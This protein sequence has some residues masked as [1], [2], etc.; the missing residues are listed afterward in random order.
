MALINTGYEATGTWAPVYTVPQG[1]TA[2]LT[3]L[4]AAG[5]VAETETAASL[6]VRWTDSSTSA[7]YLLLAG[8]LVPRGA[9]VSCVVG[10]L[11]LEEGDQVEVKASASAAIT[12]TLSAEVI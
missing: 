5:I 8:L 3:Q 6:D 10:E 11:I 9:A 12:I 4:Q 2:R 1:Q 7:S